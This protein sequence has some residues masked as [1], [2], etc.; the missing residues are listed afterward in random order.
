MQELVTTL[1]RLYQPCGLNYIELLHKMNLNA[2]NHLSL[3]PQTMVGQT[4]LKLVCD[5][6]NQL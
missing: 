6:V 2:P 5:N 3:H 1:L 4:I